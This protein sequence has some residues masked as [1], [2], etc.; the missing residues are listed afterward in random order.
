MNYKNK[1]DICHSAIIRNKNCTIF[2]ITYFMIPKHEEIN[3]A[4]KKKSL[5][6]VRQSELILYGIFLYDDDSKNSTG[7]I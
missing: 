1:N 6:G 5:F 2:L 3:F 7:T 4:G